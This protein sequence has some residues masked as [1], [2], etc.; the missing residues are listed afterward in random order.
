MSRDVRQYFENRSDAWNELYGQG[1][2]R[3][4]NRF[5]RKALYDRARLTAEALE[6]VAGKRLLDV[7]CGPGVCSVELARQGASVV[8]VDFSE[9]ML[10]LAKERA[11]RAGV[12][13]RCRF[14][15][16]DF[17]ELSPGEVFD[18]SFA[19]GVF[20]YAREPERLLAAMRRV[21]CGTLAASFPSPTLIRAPLRKLRYRLRGCPVFFYSRKRLE[22][23]YAGDGLTRARF[24]RLS[25]GWLVLA[26]TPRP[27]G[28]AA[29][30]RED[31]HVEVGELVG[32]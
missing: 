7:G 13:Q 28:A 8:G 20:D 2:E 26:E 14:V 4:F 30:R 16:G 31:R 5:F 15:L 27:R 10:E 3:R 25:A 12:A 19:L 24:V 32:V 23:L 1:A 29:I 22:R 17:L 11:E 6:P 21:T 9:S 18:G